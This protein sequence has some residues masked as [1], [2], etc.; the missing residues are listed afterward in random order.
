MDNPDFKIDIPKRFYSDAEGTPFDH[1]NVCGKWLLDEGTSYVVEKAM[2]NYEGF[3]FSSTIY[4]FAICTPCHMKMQKGMSEESMANLQSY[5]AHF[6]EE[7]KNRPIHIDLHSFDLDQWLSK[8]FFK[9]DT[10]RDMKEYQ[11]VAQFNGS[12]MLLTAPPMIIGETAMN[13]M[14]ALMSDKTIDEMNGF[15]DK[16][17]GP[18]PEI[19]ELLYGKRLIMI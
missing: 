5:Y 8:C 4:E 1:C 15:R 6:M 7:R 9:G 12:K 16:F 13:E 18:P 11:I 2:K 14:S 3:D 17:L 19:E 10:I